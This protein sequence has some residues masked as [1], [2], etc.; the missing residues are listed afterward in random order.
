[1]LSSGLWDHYINTHV[2]TADTHIIKNKINLKIETKFCLKIVEMVK[3]NYLATFSVE[4]FCR[5]G[6]IRLIN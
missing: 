3:K 6:N 1:M 5:R 2:L 4:V